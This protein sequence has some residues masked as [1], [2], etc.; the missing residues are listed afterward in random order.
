MCEAIRSRARAIAT[1]GATETVETAAAAVELPSYWK[2]KTMTPMVSWPL[3][4]R[5]TEKA[6]AF[7]AVFS[8]SIAP[9][10]STGSTAGVRIAAIR[11]PA[12]QTPASSSAGAI[13]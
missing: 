8:T 13:A 9:A 2:A 7:S 12:D 5:S 3:D 11:R 1:T 10:D 6:G 4:H